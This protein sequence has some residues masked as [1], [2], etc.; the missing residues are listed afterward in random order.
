M[1]T[2]CQF[3]GHVSDPYTE[4]IPLHGLGLMDRVSL[5]VS[6]SVGTLTIEPTLDD[7]IE[8]TYA[9]SSSNKAVYETMSWNK[10]WDDE[11][12]T[13]SL[14]STGPEPRSARSDEGTVESTSTPSRLDTL[15]HYLFKAGHALLGRPLAETLYTS[16]G[17]S[18]WWC[19]E[20]TVT[21]KMPTEARKVDLTVLS[22]DTDVMFDCSVPTSVESFTLTTSGGRVSMSSLSA[23]TLTVTD[24]DSRY[25]IE[26]LS[27]SSAAD[28]TFTDSTCTLHGFGGRTLM[29]HAEG[30]DMTIDLGVDDYCGEFSLLCV[31]TDEEPHRCSNA[32]MSVYSLVA[33][34]LVTTTEESATKVQGYVG[35]D[36]CKGNN[37]IC[38]YSS[39]VVFMNVYETA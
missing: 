8:V 7:E 3:P 2:R 36:T 9:Y 22:S 29:T 31:P 20:F 33:P 18:P 34:Q 28:M 32:R 4:R 39:G 19:P 21:I 15:R 37:S 27:V 13:Y 1:F 25:Y 35:R 6:M 5:T 23:S 30:G 10:V 24:T 26:D 14:S 16:Q 11:N 12:L 17:V 38:V